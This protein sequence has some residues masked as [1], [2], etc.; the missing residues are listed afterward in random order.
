MDL[1][2]YNI[3]IVYM[4]LCPNLYTYMATIYR[5]SIQYI[6]ICYTH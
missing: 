5:A 3:H 1:Q 2:L 4:A 6:H